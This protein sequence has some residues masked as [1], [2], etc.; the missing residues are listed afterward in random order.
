M[1]TTVKQKGGDFVLAPAGTHRARCYRIV[2]LGTQP[3]NWQ[4]QTKW[5]PKVLIGWELCDE[6]M[7]DGKPFTVS[8]R[9]TASLSDKA[10]LRHVLE[11]WRG[12]P[13]T[14]QE[15]EGFQLKKVLSAPCLLTVS[16][17]PSKDGSKT[18][19]NIKA[20]TALAK[21]MQQPL[22]LVNAALHYEIEQHRDEAFNSFPDWLKDLIGKCKEWNTT[23]GEAEAP[24]ASE[25]TQA[26][27]AA[28][29]NI[30]F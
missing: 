26:G 5:Q 13:F 10:N 4:N 20:V 28:E 8:A 19:A 3:V 27:D 11:A 17:E 9:Y 30:P 21:G 6:P 23:A 18:Y 24:A 2:D 1:S 7:E 29:D 14:S 22:P 15:L 16:H 25:G 12:K